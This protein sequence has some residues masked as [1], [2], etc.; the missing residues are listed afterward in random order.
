M[1]AQEKRLH[2]DEEFRRLRLALSEAKEVITQKEEEIE[3]LEG[4]LQM[5]RSS[6]SQ[7]EDEL[8]S[9][10]A[11]TTSV[12]KKAS[13]LKVKLAQLLH[14]N[15]DRLIDSPKLCQYYFKVSKVLPLI[16]M[17]Q[18]AVLFLEEALDDDLAQIAG[19]T[20]TKVS[21]SDDVEDRGRA[22]PRS[23]SRRACLCLFLEYLARGDQPKLEIARRFGYSSVD[24]P[25]K[26]FEAILEQF[27]RKITPRLL[28]LQPIPEL[29]KQC[30]DVKVKRT[31]AKNVSL[32]DQV[33][34][35]FGTDAALLL[36]DGAPFSSQSSGI[37]A[38]QR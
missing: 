15:P 21:L 18:E 27:S 4:E 5:L 11:K 24:E 23:L 13:S 22:R 3:V 26:I 28:Y 8:A 29:R 36:T 7:I 6:L 33:E 25:N 12:Q 34:A 31:D 2:P 1:E 38:L 32:L 19:G 17:Q 37:A 20:N 16:L 14:S 35:L 9:T 10:T 30:A